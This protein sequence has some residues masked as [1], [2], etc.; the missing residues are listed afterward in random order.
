MKTETLMKWVLKILNLL[1][2][3]KNHILKDSKWTQYFTYMKLW[4]HLKAI[5]QNTVGI[6]FWHIGGKKVNINL[7]FFA[8]ISF[9]LLS[10]LELPERKWTII[11]S[12]CLI[13]CAILPI[14]RLA[15]SIQ[16]LCLFVL[17]VLVSSQTVLPEHYFVLW[18]TDK[19]NL[20][21]WKS[22]QKMFIE[23]KN[24]SE[25]IF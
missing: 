21:I 1:I 14:K 8:L 6:I 22:K 9:N 19:I 23:C 4:R 12:H 18:F 5:K 24:T 10:N 11:N 7:S 20:M 17:C 25:Q 15:L 16:S 13:F 3:W 2:C